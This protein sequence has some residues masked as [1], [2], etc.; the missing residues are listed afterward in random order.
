MDEDAAQ[1][2]ADRAERANHHRRAQ[3][4]RSEEEAAKAQVL[5]DRFVAQATQA[6]L[7][8]EELTARPWSGR[9]R[10]RTGVVGWYL[11]TDRSIGVGQD[12]SYYVLVVPPVR[13]G[14]WR[15]LELEPTLPALVVGKGARDGES[16]ALDALLQ[17]RLQS[18]GSGPTWDP[19]ETD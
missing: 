1:R 11:R 13:F 14:R 15:T 17:M 19:P 4:A 16:V 8:T 6:G 2:R 3:L 5:I 18:S 7:P 10:Y 9:G 12:G